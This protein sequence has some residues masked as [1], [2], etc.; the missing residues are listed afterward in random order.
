MYQGRWLCLNILYA[1]SFSNNTAVPID[2][3]NYKDS[4]SLNTHTTV[5]SWGSGHSNK[6]LM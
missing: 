5:F 2:L 3:N 1:C 6:N 4:L